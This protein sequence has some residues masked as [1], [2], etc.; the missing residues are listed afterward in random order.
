MKAKEFKRN[1]P[2]GYYELLQAGF[3]H[4]WKEFKDTFEQQFVGE[5]GDQFD[6]MKHELKD[7]HGVDVDDWPHCHLDLEA[8][9]DGFVDDGYFVIEDSGYFVFRSC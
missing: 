9:W 1:N 3:P 5:F 7:A 6:F 4:D 8:I 2:D